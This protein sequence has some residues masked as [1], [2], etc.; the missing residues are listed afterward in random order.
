MDQPSSTQS[1]NGLNIPFFL[2]HSSQQQT[3]RL[4]E[5]PNDLLDIIS[6][7]TEFNTD[8]ETT[9]RERTLQLKS[10]PPELLSHDAKEGQLHLCTEDKA[11]A[12][13]Q[14]S[15]SNS[16][17]IAKWNGQSASGPVQTFSTA[18]DVDMTDGETDDHSTETGLCLHALAQQNTVL[19]L[20]PVTQSVEEVMRMAMTLVPPYD[21]SSKEDP[22]DRLVL[23]EQYTTR[24]LY[25]EIPAPDSLIKK[26]LDRLCCFEIGGRQHRSHPRSNDTAN[27]SACSIPTTDTILDVWRKILDT[28]VIH[29][30]RLLGHIDIPHLLVCLRNDCD[31]IDPSAL[32]EEGVDSQSDFHRTTAAVIN[33]VQGLLYH[34]FPELQIATFAPSTSAEAC[35]DTSQNSTLSLNPQSV[36]SFLGQL[37]VLADIQS[38]QS[39]LRQHTNFRS[40]CP[41]TTVPAFLAIFLSR[42]RSLLPLEAH[43]GDSLNPWLQFITL[44]N[45]GPDIT[46]TLSGNATATM[47]TSHA[48]DL[49]IH[50]ASCTMTDSTMIS[51]CMTQ[52]RLRLPDSP[53]C[54][55]CGHG[56]RDFHIISSS[57]R[58]CDGSQTYD[59]SLFDC[60]FV[61]STTCSWRHEEQE[62]A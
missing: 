28:C 34:T 49:D 47:N 6:P 43:H 35:N 3:L 53:T 5:L 19:E 39:D 15:T 48:D 31:N 12:V 57:I 46:Y 55:I 7:A 58:I 54:R 14:V 26:A 29:S 4:L 2:P 52:D 17:Y 10:A 8:N 44:S 37:L 51:F 23:Q 27:G 9:R 41:V 40:D 36:A 38:Q 18:Q 25:D 20:L 32:I 42:W 1:D 60:E 21:I 59:R 30:L 22:R 61:R 13:R 11:W 24:Q 62:M 45:L 16:V 33:I 50:E 56:R